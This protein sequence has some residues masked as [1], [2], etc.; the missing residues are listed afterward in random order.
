MVGTWK[1]VDLL[2]RLF[3]CTI[4]QEMHTLAGTAELQF[5]NSNQRIYHNLKSMVDKIEFREPSWISYNM[6]IPE[7]TLTLFLEQ[8]WENSAG[9]TLHSNPHLK[10]LFRTRHIS[11]LTWPDKAE[12]CY[13]IIEILF[14]F[15][16]QFSYLSWIIIS[17][18]EGT[19]IPNKVRKFKIQW[20]PRDPV[21]IQR[22]F[23]ELA[24]E[25]QL[26]PITSNRKGIW[27]Q[28][29]DPNCQ[30]KR[31]TAHP[32]RNR[33]HQRPENPKRTNWKKKRPKRLRTN[34]SPPKWRWR[35]FWTF[36]FDAKV[37]DFPP[38]L[39]SFW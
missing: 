8:S 37:S 2:S 3:F 33:I 24:I 34:D 7:I 31:R 39:C 32:Q 18:K 21:S 13:C 17:L 6:Q 23:C 20:T 1:P 12:F 38:E 29:S 16:S 27:H 22:Y 36:W 26:D 10:G 9:I 4:A 30:P 28:R 14:A 5:Q 35:V 19:F 11:T 15:N 25:S